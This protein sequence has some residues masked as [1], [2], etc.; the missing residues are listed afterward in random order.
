MALQNNGIMPIREYLS[1]TLYIP[2]YQR[3]YSWEEVEL[4]DFWVDLLTTV[5]DNDIH[6]FGQ[7]VIH[8]DEENKKLFIID[9]QQRTITSVI[10]L[11]AL[12]KVYSE[13]SII[14][15]TP[16][17]KGMVDDITSLIGRKLRKSNDLHLVLGNDDRDYFI[18]RI[19]MGYPDPTKKEKKKSQDRMR[20][21][22]L[23]FETKING[24]I[25][26]KSEEDEVL[27]ALEEIYHVFKDNFRLLYMEATKLNEAFI[28]FETLNARGKDLETADLLKNYIFSKVNDVKEAEKK[29]S[30]MV[31]NLDGIDP[32]KFIRH[33]WNSTYEF[34]RE[35]E[36]YKRIVKTIN[37]PKKS[38]EFLEN[39]AVYA[40]VYHDLSSPTDS[41]FFT[42]DRLRESLISLKNMKASAF[43]PVVLA[44][45]DQKD[46]S[47]ADIADIVRTI[48]VYVF[49]NFAIAGKSANT[50]EV[51]FA[52]VAKD[53]SDQVLTSKEDIQK[54][55]SEKMISNDEFGSLFAIWKGSNSA[56]DKFI[57]R[58]IFRK[59]HSYLSATSEVVLDNNKVHIE[60]IMPQEGSLWTNISKEVHDNCLWRLGNLALLDAALNREQ[61]NKPF[62]E[63][64]KFFAKSEIKPNL[65]IAAQ[66][67]WGENEI[68]ERQI[69]L[70]NYALQ[71]WK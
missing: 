22:F 59:I 60:H 44:L 63:K 71:I 47:D 15:D 37:T 38:K 55:I 57:V 45:A 18:D 4:E 24:I 51:F 32:T 42:N 66:P 30:E 68:N 39:L 26:G 65:E 20:K 6:F 5:A 56:V 64:K 69:Q 43:Y 23:Y 8:N 50:S 21:A 27:D 19:Q 53:I 29:W 11:R 9:G 46:F 7:V 62:D 40:L 1:K 52:K 48:E 12:Q 28:I 31:N 58:Y 14:K 36:L 54:Q 67:S 35:K 10:F 13:N 41:S 34:S 61:Q 70:A 16:D 2:T 49:R 25:Q 3:E 33:L 17:A